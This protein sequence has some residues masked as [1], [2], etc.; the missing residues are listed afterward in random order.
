M[1]T[2]KAEAENE[3]IQERLIASVYRCLVLQ[4]GQLA[5]DWRHCGKAA[6]LR[7]RRCR[8]A[9]CVLDQGVAADGPD[10]FA[11]EAPQDG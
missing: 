1:T 5:R 6:C 4:A 8:G 10:A 11:G 2:E 7:S 9:G 3:A